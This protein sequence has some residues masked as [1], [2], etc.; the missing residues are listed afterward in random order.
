MSKVDFED[1]AKNLPD[2][3]NMGG[4]PQV[5]YYARYEDVSV[6]PKRPV[7]GTGVTLAKMGELTGNLEM[8]AEKFFHRLYVTDDEG[9]LDIEG[10]GEKD[11]K[12]FVMK[13][14]V[15]HPGLN[16]RLLG[17]MNLAKNSNLVF[18]VPDS[19][20]GLFLLGDEM[21]A[22]A[23]DSID[24]MTTG[25]KTEERPGAGIV[26]AY[27]TANVYRY[28]GVIP[29]NGSPAPDPDPD[30]TPDPDPDPDP[31]TLVA[32][33]PDGVDDYL[34]I[35]TNVVNASGLYPINNGEKAI[36]TIDMIPGGIILYFTKGTAF[37]FGMIYDGEGLMIVIYTKGKG[38]LCNEMT[39]TA[40]TDKRVTV[41]VEFAMVSDAPVIE[42]FMNDVKV[43]S[44]LV[45]NSD[46]QAP[47]ED[48]FLMLSDGDRSYNNGKLFSLSI[49]KSVNGAAATRSALW[50]F[51]G[52]T[53]VEKLKNKVSS[54]YKLT[55]HNVENMS[56][57]IKSV[58]V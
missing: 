53:D 25:Q 42:V 36:Y 12:S 41:R 49:D 38:Y 3:Q 45:E 5:V 51:S 56:E 17:F 40:Y 34:S 11:G 20:G 28:K 35:E 2:G 18:V 52:D 7:G 4:I 24:G 14:R 15:Y 6:W 16:S 8:K 54:S 23:M 39:E 1:I 22:A 47:A 31:T 9:K 58:T 43:N 10:V 48:K 57:F 32:C 29:L 21:R 26:F 55:A 27:K 33:C 19:N 37:Q 30:P 44:P 13:L 46:L 50:N